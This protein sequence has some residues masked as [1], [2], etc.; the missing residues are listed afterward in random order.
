MEEVLQSI[1]AELKYQTKLFEGLIDRKDCGDKKGTMKEMQ[2]QL[3]E[4]ALN[5]FKGTPM[6]EKMRET[7]EKMTDGLG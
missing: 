6:E 4:T 3:R 2:D 5:M 1:L 7:M